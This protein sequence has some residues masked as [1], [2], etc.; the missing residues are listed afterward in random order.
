MTVF[1]NHMFTKVNNLFTAL[2]AISAMFLERNLD[3]QED[4][5]WMAS[6]G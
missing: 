6:Q 2:G 3:D 5:R 4:R 1:I